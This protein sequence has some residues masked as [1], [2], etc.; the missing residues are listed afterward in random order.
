MGEVVLDGRMPPFYY[1]IEHPNATLSQ[2]E[3]E[4]LAN[5]LMATINR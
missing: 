2:T 4:Q 3:K 1:L 5:G